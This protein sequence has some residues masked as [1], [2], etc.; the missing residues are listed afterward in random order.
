TRVGVH[1]RGPR[2]DR[3]LPDAAGSRAR[4]DGDPHGRR[5]EASRLARAVVGRPSPAGRRRPAAE[6][7]AARQELPDPGGARAALFRARW[8]LILNDLSIKIPSG[9]WLTAFTGTVQVAATQGAGA[10]QSVG[11]VSFSGSTFTHLDVAKWLSRLADVNE[12]AFPYLTLSSKAGTGADV[13]VTF[14]SN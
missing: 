1:R 13:L 3:L 8:S 14:N 7:R 5:R 11:T 10:T 12:F 9:V 6:Q 2:F 4:L